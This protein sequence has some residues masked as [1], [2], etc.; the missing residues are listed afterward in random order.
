VINSA[1]PSESDGSALLIT[2]SA[3]QTTVMS[4]ETAVETTV[5]RRRERLEQALGGWEPM[6]LAA[7]FDAAAT[8]YAERPFVITDGRAWTYAGV[9]SWSR[10]LARGL[11]DLGVRPGDRVALVVD[12]RPEFVAIKLAVA[13]LG[14]VAVPIN[15]SYRAEELAVVLATAE[16]SVLVSIDASIGVDHLAGLDELV[17]GWERGATNPRLPHLR[18]VVLV[19][20]AARPG[21]P[22]LAGLA[23]RG[24]RVAEDVVRRLEADVD[25]DSVCDVVFT[26]GTSGHPLG[27]ML[28]HD[29]VTRSG[30]GSAYHRAFGPG[31]RICFSLPMYHVFG[32]IEGLVAA[33]F[34]GGAVV[35]QQV[36]NPRS[37]L[38]AIQDHRVNEVLFVPTMSVAVVEEAARTR[39]DTS[40]LESVF[41]AAAAA[42]V[43]L[44]DEI[45][46][47]LAP[48]RIFTG[49]GQTEVSA[50]TTLT[51]PGD[52]VELVAETVGREK[53]GGCAAPAGPD[54]VLARYRT[55]DPFTGAALPDGAEGEL[56]VRGPIVTRGYWGDPERTSALI[57]PTG[58]WLRTGDL[59]R[60]RP[61]GYLEL[62]G[63]SGELFK[64][65]GE[66]VAP[67][68]IEQVLTGHDGVAQAYAAGVPDERLGEV[69]WAW[70]VRAEGSSVTEAELVRH[71]R[72]RLAG[73][74]VPRKLVFLAAE[75]LPKTATGKVQKYRLIAGR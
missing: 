20:A 19:G 35:P 21:A 14:A 59:G 18:H 75:D 69:G 45:G 25:P 73:F 33:L 2:L 44:W 28:T 16:A 54:G 5:E 39:Y 9:Q 26:S 10:Q 71:C 15:F 48:R 1:E 61:D 60:I 24:E 31:W 37:I 67:K 12:N 6:G 41:S 34:A 49:Y 51:L 4:S 7:R 66:L 70:V 27:A 57:D 63:R 13:R 52:P 42:P 53:L 36:F 58:G 65:G 74:K 46:A 17:P 56:S 43:R 8:A 72:E 23:A 3:G 22:D 50:A 62:T 29:M 64:V 11:Y 47:R 40:S 32:Y 38:T 55:V 68:Q 30:Y